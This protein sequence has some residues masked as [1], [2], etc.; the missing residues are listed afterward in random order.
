MGIL[1]E[2]AKEVAREVMNYPANQKA[3]FAS[4]SSPLS[5]GLIKAII[6]QNKGQAL[7]P[8]QRDL[9]KEFI[10]FDKLNPTLF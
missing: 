9:I 7:T 2:R 10:E 6:K 8:K 5:A 4:L 1:I 3:I